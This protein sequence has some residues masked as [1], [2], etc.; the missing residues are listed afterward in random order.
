MLGSHFDYLLNSI[1][2]IF[3]DKSTAIL[4][5]FTD[6]EQEHCFGL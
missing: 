1:V 3:F 6:K 4:Q 2:V 5:F